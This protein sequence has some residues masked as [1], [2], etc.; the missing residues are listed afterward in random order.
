[1]KI[2]NKIG[3]TIT[4]F[5]LMVFG[6]LAG[7]ATETGSLIMEPGA[8]HGP[9]VEK[10]DGKRAIVTMFKAKKLDAGSHRLDMR[11]R[12]DPTA[13]SGLLGVIPAQSILLSVI[14]SKTYRGAM[15]I[16]IQPRHE[17]VIR[18]SRAGKGNWLV[19]AYDKTAGADVAQVL[20][21][22]KSGEFR[23]IL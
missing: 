13:G 2:F 12:Y 21:D 17:Y 3:T 23:Q 20:V 19:T 7:A 8:N 14:A 10:I 22:N 16:H 6:S 15:D 9:L 5:G 11:V 1:M 4:L 18:T